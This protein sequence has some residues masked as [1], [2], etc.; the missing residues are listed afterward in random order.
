MFLSGLI[1]FSC[2]L[3]GGHSDRCAFRVKHQFCLFFCFKCDPICLKNLKKSV[4][5]CRMV[6]TEICQVAASSSFLCCL[7]TITV[8]HH[9][10]VCLDQ[11]ASTSLGWVI[12]TMEPLINPDVP[13]F[14]P[15]CGYML[16]SLPVCILHLT[17]DGLHGTSFQNQELWTIISKHTNILNS[18]W[19][20]FHHVDFFPKTKILP[21]W[22]NFA[23]HLFFSSNSVKREMCWNVNHLIMQGFIKL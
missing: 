5:S 16:C 17:R 8:G 1:R 23:W 4:S 15:L 12:L 7:S 2:S 13:V 21:Q 6:W 10:A 14:L 3:G 18:M 19:V 22:I 20:I 11:E 9:G